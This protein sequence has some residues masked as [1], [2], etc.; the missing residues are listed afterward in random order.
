[1]HSRL[2][3]DLKKPFKAELPMGADPSTIEE[4]LRK[5]T[6]E[7]LDK[8]LDHYKIEPRA[9]KWL[10]LS[11]YLARELGLL[12]IADKKARGRPRTRS[13]ET[14]ADLVAEIDAI[15][16]RRKRGPSDA[17][18]ILSRKKGVKQKT[19]S[20]RYAEAKKRHM[21]LAWAIVNGRRF[22]SPEK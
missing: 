6:F 5:W 20:N 8:L 1:M 10:A 2:P 16:A 22:S 4:Q 11:F 17:T 13:L 9:D 18:A 12:N 3:L 21:P 19:L 15:R 7:K 14:E